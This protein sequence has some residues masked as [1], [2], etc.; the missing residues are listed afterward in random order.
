MIHC[1]DI[2]VYTIKI[3][4][5]YNNFFK[6][7]FCSVVTT[8]NPRSRE[9][10]ASASNETTVSRNGEKCKLTNKALKHGNDRR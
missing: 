9:P 3:I 7:V 10:L 5:V 6:Y 1:E 2:F 8:F 4:F